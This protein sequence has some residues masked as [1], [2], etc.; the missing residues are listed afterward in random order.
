MKMLSQPKLESKHAIR[1]LMLFDQLI[2]HELYIKELGL[3]PQQQKMT[4]ENIAPVLESPEEKETLVCFLNNYSL[5]VKNRTTVCFCREAYEPT[6]DLVSLLSHPSTIFSDFDKLN[7]DFSVFIKLWTYS[8][9]VS[10]A[11]QEFR[12]KKNVLFFGF[13]E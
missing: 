4:F 8:L 9:N 10:F 13:E 12:E 7:Y 5:L 11:S 2:D 3:F 6:N 1:I